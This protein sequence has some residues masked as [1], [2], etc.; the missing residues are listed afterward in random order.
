[1]EKPVIGIR[2]ADGSFYQIMDESLVGRKRLV[3][4]AART[5]QRG[6][7]I[8]L[9]RSADG[10][11]DSATPLG[12]IALDDPEGLGYKDIEFRVDIG[13]DALLAASAALPGQTP[14]SLSVDL[15]P[16]RG[17]RSDAAV[18]ADDSLG[19]DLDTLDD[20]FLSES[21]PEQE[22]EVMTLDLPEVD[23]LDTEPVRSDA[24]ILNDDHFDAAD[25]DTLDDLGLDAPAQADSA[26]ADSLDLADFGA[27]EGI[28]EQDSLELGDLDSVENFG[29]AEEEPVEAGT[30]AEESFDLGDLDA[31]FSEPSKTDPAADDPPWEKISLDDMESMEF[32]DTGDEISS[33]PPVPPAKKASSD[34]FSM[35]DDVPL[36]LNDL[37][38]DLSD[39]P[40]MDNLGQNHP[41]KPES[42]DE[43]NDFDMDFLPPPALTETPAWD[44]KPAS[45]GKAEKKSREPKA[46]KAPKARGSD[47]AAPEESGPGGLDKTAL[48]LSLAALSLL[49]LLIL[50]LLFLNMIKAPPA[51]V[52]QPEVMGWDRTQMVATVPPSPSSVD[53]GASAP[54]T[55]EASSVLEVPE[56]LR[57]AKITLKLEPGETVDDAARRFGPPAR[58]Q[59]NQLSW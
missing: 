31:G 17:P 14:K 6:V 15:S 3:L 49:V 8:D 59:G 58:V 28:S 55:F 27:P 48:F 47:R 37:D 50:V 16:Y 46:A 57:H 22:P 32:M 24:D 19:A 9:F 10:T 30:P 2:Q 34:D 25:L 11:L 35:D 7:K 52:I 38:S 5:D 1:V 54:V 13:E 45:K 41:P 23:D 29:G 44:D 39:L 12:T 43:A 36:E 40:D 33:S 56:G 42:S 4:S 18:L 26:D 20:S 21:S 53:L 51:P